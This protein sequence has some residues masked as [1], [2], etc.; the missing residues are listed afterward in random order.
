VVEQS[1]EHVRGIS[2]GRVD[3]LGVKRRVLVG[4]VGVEE[5]SRLGA[6][7]KIDLA[8][9]LPAATGPELLSVGRRSRDFVEKE[10]P[11]WLQALMPRRINAPSDYWPQKVLALANPS[12]Y[13]QSTD[14]GCRDET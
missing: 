6:V 3:Y 1:I 14:E 8:R 4:Y 12:G 5:Y 10:R 2:Y 7:T 13:L 11:D 9:L